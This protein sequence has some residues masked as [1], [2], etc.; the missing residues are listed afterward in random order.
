MICRRLLRRKQLRWGDCYW[1]LPPLLG[2]ALMAGCHQATAERAS[3]TQAISAT[4]Q[5][6]RDSTT[7]ASGAG[8]QASGPKQLSFAEPPPDDLDGGTLIEET[9][10]AVSMQGTRVG[11][12][13]T[14]VANVNKEERDLV[15]SSSF[16]RVVL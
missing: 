6:V 9:W 14:T 10:D 16:V 12:V 11:Y 13:H 2:V 7:A 5:N 3:E 1:F 15:R 4:R 8:R